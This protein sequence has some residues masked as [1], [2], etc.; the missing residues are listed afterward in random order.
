MPRKASKDHAAEPKV[1][2]K[3]KKASQDAEPVEEIEFPLKDFISSKKTRKVLENRGIKGLFP[4]QAKTYNEIYEGKNIVGRERTGCGKTLAFALPIV[5]RLRDEGHFKETRR[6]QK[7]YV[8]I[9]L[10]TR[11]LAIQVG[12]EIDTL[13]HEENEYRVVRVYGGTDLREQSNELRNG[14]EI[15]VGTPGRILDQ[16]ERRNLGFDQLKVIILDEADQMM[17]LGF[18]EDVEKIYEAITNRSDALQNL[19]FSATVPSWVWQ[20]VKAFVG[21]EYEYIDLVKNTENKTAKKVEHYAIN[22]P[23]FARNS[24]VGDVVL[25]YGGIHCRTII[26]T[27]TKKDANEIMLNSKIKGECQV[28]HGDIPQKQREITFQAFKDG[29]VKCLI[30]TNVAARGLDIPEIDLVIQ[31]DPPKDVETYIHRAGRTGRAG[32]KGVCVVFYSKKQIGL[33]EKVE[34]KANFKFKKI[35]A[36]QQ[37]DVIKASC[38]EV[39]TGLESVNPDMLPVFEESAQEIIDKIGERTAL[40]RALAYISGYTQEI[41]Q[42]SLM[43]GIEG[44]ITYVINCPI[45]FR[46]LGYIWNFLRNNFDQAVVNDIKGLKPLANKMGAVF[47]I[48]SENSSAFDDY[49]KQ[50]ESG[51]IN[52]KGM[53]IMKATE[54][55]DIDEE[56]PNNNRSNNFQRDNNFNRDRSNNFQRDNRENN[57]D[58]NR[59]SG[60]GRTRSAGRPEKE[61]EVFVGSLPYDAEERNVL[62]FFKSEGVNLTG[63]RMLKDGDKSKGI[64]F[65]M[66]AS[67]DDF[68]KALKMDNKRFWTRNIRVNPAS[69]K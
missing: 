33:V 65:A 46:S 15:I 39:I 48:T 20:I 32:R 60:Y 67:K 27:E 18:K 50:S 57:R 36:P 13:K 12:K 30:A 31:I 54:L 26:F 56:G 37:K 52:A 51:E 7:P 55:P 29:K 9:V 19:L 45:E 1:T 6:G 66:A 3:T 16:I 35:G 11:E 44:Y 22:C 8:L 68:D 63:I 62:D 69:R 38:K 23:Y 34:S 47:D 28:L 25:C 41:T 4:I 53:M 64:G 49:I 10:P 21:V 58:N 61:L 43:C 14:A 59:D 2:K 24:T 5:E 42:R 40:I 17:D